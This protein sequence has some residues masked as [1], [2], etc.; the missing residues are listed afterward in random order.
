[1]TFPVENQFSFHFHYNLKGRKTAVPA[2]VCGCFP[3]ITTST[4]QY[5]HWRQMKQFCVQVIEINNGSVW[6]FCSDKFLYIF[7][8]QSK[9]QS[10]FLVTFDDIILPLTPTQH[11]RR[12]EMCPSDKNSLSS[13]NVSKSRSMLDKLDKDTAGLSSCV[14]FTQS[15][16]LRHFPPPGQRFSHILGEQVAGNHPRPTTAFHHHG[17][18]QRFIPIK[19]LTGSVDRWRENVILGK[20]KKQRGEKASVVW[21]KWARQRASSWSHKSDYESNKKQI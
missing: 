8:R 6:S 16:S 4:E 15:T 19:G 2:L 14:D 20:K 5:S 13:W 12:A 18:P 3:C 1:M 10:G 11:I 21:V 17:S 7:Q 9:E